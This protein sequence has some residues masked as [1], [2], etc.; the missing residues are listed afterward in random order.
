VLYSIIAMLLSAA[1][2]IA[3]NLGGFILGMILSLV[4]CALA[5]AWTPLPGPAPDPDPDS[6]S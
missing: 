3:S 1:S 2:W 4:G 5:F 6:T